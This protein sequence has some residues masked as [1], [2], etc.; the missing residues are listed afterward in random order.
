MDQNHVLF[1]IITTD[2]NL[3]T[4]YD[5]ANP[6]LISSSFLSSK[7][8]RE[9]EREGKQVSERLLG[10]RGYRETER[11]GEKGIRKVTW[12]LRVYLEGISLLLSLESREAVAI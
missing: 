7:G 1:T 12:L 4:Y 11:E 6:Y 2:S 10:Y 5:S 8:R 3:R 9:T